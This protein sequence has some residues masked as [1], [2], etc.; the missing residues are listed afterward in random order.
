MND[1]ND[2]VSSRHEYRR[3]RE[4][5]KLRRDS[6][7]SYAR[8]KLEHGLD[9]APIYAKRNRATSIGHSRREARVGL[10]TANVLQPPY[11]RDN[12]RH[13]RGSLL[14]I[15]DAR[16][17]VVLPNLESAIP[18]VGLKRPEAKRPFGETAATWADGLLISNSLTSQF[19]LAL[20]IANADI[21]DD[22]EKAA[23]SIL[24]H[25]KGEHIL[26]QAHHVSLAV[27]RAIASLAAALRAQSFD[28][29]SEK[30]VLSNLVVFGGM[31]VPHVWDTLRIF[32]GF[33]KNARVSECEISTQFALYRELIDWIGSEI[34]RPY[35]TLTLSM[36]GA[37]HLVPSPRLKL[38]PALGWRRAERAESF[39]DQ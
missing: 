3:K 39:P 28:L 25:D 18:V 17:I 30:S 19:L 29:A 14:E 32:L 31:F 21:F 36:E 23:S 1:R 20:A 37:V 9:N 7:A 8:G 34:D 4:K 5:L 12:I 35:G 2:G 38:V 33:S 22:D 27:E 24:I 11:A 13:A 10:R 26:E 15:Q 6:S 16:R